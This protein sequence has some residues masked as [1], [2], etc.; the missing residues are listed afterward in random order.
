MTK[1]VLDTHLSTHPNVMIFLILSD[2]NSG[3]IFGPGNKPN[4]LRGK[5]KVI[6]VLSVIQYRLIDE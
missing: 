3:S 2:L 4:K 6:C 1:Y 5:V